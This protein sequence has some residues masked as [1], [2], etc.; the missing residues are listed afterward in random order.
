MSVNAPEILPA[1]RPLGFLLRD[2]VAPLK[3]NLGLLLGP[4]V[5]LIIW[6]LPTGLEPAQQ[7]TFAII[8]FMIIYWLAEPIDHGLTALIGCYLFWA[9]NVV[10]FLRCVQW[11]REFYRMVP[12]RLYPHG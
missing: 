4:I 1:H 11:F 10:K 12:L 5:A 9:L 7:K 2:A 6:F 8:A 3:S